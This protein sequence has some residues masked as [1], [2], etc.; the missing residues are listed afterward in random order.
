MGNPEVKHGCQNTVTTAS[1]C[2]MTIDWDEIKR[3]IA[4]FKTIEKESLRQSAEMVER[5]TCNVCGRKPTVT[6]DFCGEIVVVCPHIWYVLQRLPKAA[7]PPQPPS[8]LNGGLRIEVFDD[9]PA[10]W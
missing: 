1:S 5:T 4:K 7:E 6:R 9:G 8:V 2:T 10:R 3:V